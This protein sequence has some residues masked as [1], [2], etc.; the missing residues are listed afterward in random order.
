MRFLYLL[1]IVASNLVT[2]R[3]NPIVLANGML[4][5]PM[6]SLFAGAIF[7]L[8]DFVQ[9]KHGKRKTYLTIFIAAL[10]SALT[11]VII[12]DTAHVAIASTIAFFISEAVDTE[13]FSRVKKSL[14]VR[15]LLSGVVGGCL[16]SIIFVIL[17]LSPIGANMLVWKLVPYAILGQLLIK[18][19]VQL[20]ASIYLI[21]LKKYKKEAE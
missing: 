10:L 18:T 13:I 3:F 11:S 4:I 1:L 8:R 14:P 20:I 21:I 17:G 6:G 16:D 19:I 7:V 9:I 12:G 5:I 15:V 2:A